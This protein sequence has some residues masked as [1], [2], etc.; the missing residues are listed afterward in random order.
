MKDKDNRKGFKFFTTD[1]VKLFNRP[2]THNFFNP[3]R[4][5]YL[6]KGG[7]LFPTILYRLRRTNLTSGRFRVA[8]AC[9]QG[10]DKVL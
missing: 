2:D 6:E 3:V 7:D 4:T 5:G 10:R 8:P 9:R 1:R